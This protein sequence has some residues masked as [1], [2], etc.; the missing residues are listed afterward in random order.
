MFSEI[1]TSQFHARLPWE[2]QK[3]LKCLHVLRKKTM[4]NL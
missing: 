4:A 2:K 3:L 1:F